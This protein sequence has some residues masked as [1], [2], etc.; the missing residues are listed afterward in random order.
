MGCQDIYP[1]AAFCKSEAM[2]YNEDSMSV[3]SVSFTQVS[4][5]SLSSILEVDSSGSAVIVLS[6]LEESEDI[7]SLYESTVTS[8]FCKKFS[9][10]TFSRLSSL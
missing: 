2:Q 7:V 3:V 4:F 9:S 1:S 6:S 10:G 8:L 5:S